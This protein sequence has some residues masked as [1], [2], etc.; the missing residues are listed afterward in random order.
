MAHPAKCPHPCAT[1]CC[2]G[3]Q[4]LWSKLWADAWAISSRVRYVSLKFQSVPG[5][6]SRVSDTGLIS[7]HYAPKYRHQ[8]PDGRNGRC[9]G[10]WPHDG[11][12]A[13]GAVAISF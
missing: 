2:H 12:V 10:C 6:K 5:L 7:A 9:S 4:R 3:I 1:V 11:E 8:G 13:G